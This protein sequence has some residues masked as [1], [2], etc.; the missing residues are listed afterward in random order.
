MLPQSSSTTGFTLV[1]LIIVIVIIGILS[2]FAA[3]RFIDISTDAKIA[4]IQ[5]IAS[6][7]KAAAALAQNKA[8]A[9]GLRS[10]LVNPGYFVDFPFGTSEVDF[11]NLCPESLA[12]GADQL[13]MLDFL[14]L[15]DD[16]ETRI[17]NQY[18]LIGY[19]L[20]SSGQP[21]NQGCY[22]IYDSF[23]QPNC[24]VTPVLADC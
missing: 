17:T 16:L 20:P 13:S 15:S 7:V 11:R 12:E 22:V 19:D 14:D 6:Q 3:P 1:E 21:T 9:Q 8:R 18:T 23:G 2:I 10:A 24:T 4:S 5:A